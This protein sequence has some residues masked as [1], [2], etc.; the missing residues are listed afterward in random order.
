VQLKANVS[1]IQ[2]SK[3]KKYNKKN[4]DEILHQNTKNTKQRRLKCLCF[5]NK[6]EIN[7]FIISIDA[8]WTTMMMLPYR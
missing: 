3:H 5:L 2:T 8:E 4:K 6:I 7:L 1:K